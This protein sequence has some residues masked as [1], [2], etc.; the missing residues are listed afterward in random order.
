[1]PRMGASMPRSLKKSHPQYSRW[2]VTPAAFTLIE[3]LVVTAIIAILASLLLP[4][5][6]T[7]KVK[8]QAMICLNNTKQLII[9][10]SLYPADFN[11]ILVNNHGDEEIR[12]TRDSWVNNLLD[13][14]SNP[15]NTNLVFLA[16]AKL[17]P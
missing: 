10:W 4:A 2:L 13:W 12:I 17:A 8:A 11:E 6:S 1:M 9:A 14:G 3:L 15:E 16:D 7:T 5:L